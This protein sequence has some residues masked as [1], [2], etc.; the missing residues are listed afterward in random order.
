MTLICFECMRICKKK[1]LQ[2]Y[3]Y[4][5]SLNSNEILLKYRCFYILENMINKALIEINLLF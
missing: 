3:F 1:M 2:T 4:Q 5:N